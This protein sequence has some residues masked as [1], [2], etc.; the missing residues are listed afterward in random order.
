MGR[1]TGE[2]RVMAPEMRRAITRWIIQAALGLVGYGLILFLVAG[3]L[4]WVW[5]WVLL[6]VIATFLAAHPL[7]LVP[8]NQELLAE[9]RYRL[10]PGVW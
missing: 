7:L 9:R 3:R 6:G 10:L 4:D 5:G 1:G 2:R 8:I